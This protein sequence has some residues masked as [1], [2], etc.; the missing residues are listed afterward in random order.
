MEKRCG[1]RSWN[2]LPHGW[3][4]NG[5]AGGRGRRRGDALQTEEHT[6]H[7]MGRRTASPERHV[8]VLTPPM[9]AT[10][11]GNRVSADVIKLS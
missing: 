4:S 3:Q 8:H 10:F 9:N 7:V 6:A 11:F 2:R 5:A 1:W